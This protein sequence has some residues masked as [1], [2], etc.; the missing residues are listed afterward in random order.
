MM[1][2]LIFHFHRNEYVAHGVVM[3]I[4]HVCAREGWSERCCVCVGVYHVHRLV[5]AKVG[6][7]GAKRSRDH[8]LAMKKRKKKDLVFLFLFY[9]TSLLFLP[10]FSHLFAFISY[11][12]LLTYLFVVLILRLAIRY[13]YC[14]NLGTYFVVLAF[15]SPIA[16]SLPRQNETTFSN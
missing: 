14:A 7:G 6:C 11:V 15:I 5:R 8:F 10:L 12:F 16:L 2:N 13:S 3:M 4:V 1:F 9:F